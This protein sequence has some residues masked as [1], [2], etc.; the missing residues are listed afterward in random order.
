MKAGTEI[1]HK[2]IQ[3]GAVF[4]HQAAVSLNVT[5]ISCVFDIRERYPPEG[6]RFCRRRDQRLCFSYFSFAY[7][8]ETVKCRVRD[9]G[10][11]FVQNVFQ[12]RAAV[13][14]AWTSASSYIY[15][16]ATHKREKL[17]LVTV[18]LQENQSIQSVLTWIFGILER[19]YV[20][21][22]PFSFH[23]Y[24]RLHSLSRVLFAQTV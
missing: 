19:H 23:H 11:Y 21:P 7:E 5:K 2:R 24:R 9:S 1:T 6:T 16:K 14:G 10:L 18:L 4:M 20:G 13:G 22:G 3:K 17:G 8:R 12:R 15:H